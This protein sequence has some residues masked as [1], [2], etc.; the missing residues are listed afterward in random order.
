MNPAV[1]PIYRSTRW[2]VAINRGTAR[3]IGI[4]VPPAV[5]MQANEVFD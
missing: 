4:E 5:R 2:D 3:A 1:I